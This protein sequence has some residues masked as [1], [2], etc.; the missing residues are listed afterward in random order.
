MNSPS[1]TSVDTS[2]KSSETTSKVKPVTLL[3]NGVDINFMSVSAKRSLFES[4]GSFEAEISPQSIYSPLEEELQFEVRVY[5]STFMVGWVDSISRSYGAM[6]NTLK[7][8]GRDYGQ[9]WIDNDIVFSNTYSGSL[10][11]IIKKVLK[12]NKSGTVTDTVT[13]KQVSWSMPDAVLNWAIEDSVKTDP[14][15]A[16]AIKSMNAVTTN[17]GESIH[18]F[19]SRV[20]N[21]LGLLIYTDATGK[22]LINKALRSDVALFSTLTLNVFK[23]GDGS[24]NFVQLA[25]ESEVTGKVI[26][27][28]YN[29]SANYHSTYIVNGFSSGSYSWENEPDVA[30]AM[31]FNT[32]KLYNQNLCARSDDKWPGLKKVK[33]LTYDTAT[34]SAWQAGNMATTGRAVEVSNLLGLNY[35]MAIGTSSKPHSFVFDVN[36]VVWVKDGYLGISEQVPF[37]V[38]AVNISV[39]RKDGTQAKVTLCPMLGPDDLAEIRPMRSQYADYKASGNKLGKEPTA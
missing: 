39:D 2:T 13:K 20:C 16:A 14:K 7:L 15:I 34:Q 29:E 33:C 35:T 21:P 5:D 10:E 37:L 30:D 12:R 32:R 36:R 24:P 27:C 17:I 31:Q 38:S 11:D 18:S 6:S 22:I 25:G 26:S 1:T 9:A 4:C 19:V 28:E 3:I 8:S 23:R